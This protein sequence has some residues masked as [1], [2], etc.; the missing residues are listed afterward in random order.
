MRPSLHIFH[1]SKTVVIVVVAARKSESPRRLWEM[2]KSFK[3][4][5]LARRTVNDAAR[6]SLTLCLSHIIF[7]SSRELVWGVRRETI[8]LQCRVVFVSGRLMI[9]FQVWK[10]LK[11][12]ILLPSILYTSLRN[13]K[14]FIS[15]RPERP[16]SLLNIFRIW[17]KSWE[18]VFTH[19]W[20]SKLFTAERSPCQS[21]LYKM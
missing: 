11:I 5:F 2:L 18:K 1:N 7:S 6:V 9:V 10:E 14:G 15:D 20:K 17:T 16:E 21:R 4:F 8:A 12:Y 13:K 3:L 19:S